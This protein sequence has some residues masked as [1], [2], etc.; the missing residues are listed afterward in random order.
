MHFQ[1]FLLSILG[2]VCISL[3]ARSA[4]FEGVP[5][6][7]PAA[8]KGRK[9]QEYPP[10]FL[11][12]R[13]PHFNIFWGSRSDCA[14][15][16]SLDLIPDQKHA[17][18]IQSLIETTLES[19]V[20]NLE[21][22]AK[23][24]VATWEN[25]VSKVLY[26]V[27]IAIGL[28]DPIICGGANQRDLRVYAGEGKSDVVVLKQLLLESGGRLRN[29]Q[30][31]KGFIS[32]KMHELGHLVARAVGYPRFIAQ[33]SMYTAPLEEVV[34]DF[35]G[36]IGNGNNPL[37]GEGLSDIVDSEYCAKLTGPLDNFAR[38]K[39]ESICRVHSSA[40]MRD[41]RLPLLYPDLY[42]FPEHH[43]MAGHTNALFYRV[44][45]LAGLE[46]LFAAFMTEFFAMESSV[47]DAEIFNFV[48]RVGKRLTDQRP[49]LAIAME[50][51]FDD[52]K[53][54]QAQVSIR[55]LESKLVQDDGKIVQLEIK[56]Q[57]SL[58]AEVYD[59]PF[60]NVN[61]KSENETRFSLTW[62]GEFWEPKVTLTRVSACQPGAH[63]C[64]CFADGQSLTIDSVFLNKKTQVMRTLSQ[65]LLRFGVA[66]RSG[67][68]T[69]GAN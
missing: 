16:P 18:E 10:L 11:V 30:E 54:S 58:I 2:L 23:V 50:K 51:L 32:I 42:K 60:V 24:N 17:E 56:P 12:K 37:I 3:T 69:F 46:N 5:L 67:C 47:F 20:E 63:D 64:R 29:S 4:V 38:A 22:F 53:W 31:Q 65:E 7:D 35:V 27:N 49:A 36:F 26:P 39:I 19:Q 66:L 62:M 48:S 43:H 52:L 9:L 25:R 44:G 40:A 15:R 28:E 6:T 33:N 14:D 8:F 41:L 68:F 55:R 13:T 34:A 57:P 21:R 61:V 1:G 59:F 45:S